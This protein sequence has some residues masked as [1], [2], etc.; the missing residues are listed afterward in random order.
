MFSMQTI[1]FRPARCMMRRR[2]KF[3]STRFSN[4]AVPRRG[5]GFR[6]AIPPSTLKYGHTRIPTHASD[7]NLRLDKEF[8][9][10]CI[11]IVMCNNAGIAG[12]YRLPPL[13]RVEPRSQPGQCRVRSFL[14]KK[15][16]QTRPIQLHCSDGV[17]RM[18]F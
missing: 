15:I 12:L 10:S 3:L 11:P 17:P 1:R 9:I 5:R 2:S 6:R 18:L 8:M 4:P 7:R 16:E 14:R 13:G